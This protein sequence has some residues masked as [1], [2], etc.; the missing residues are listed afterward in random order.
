MYMCVYFMYLCIVCVYMCTEVGNTQ[1]KDQSKS[2][3]LDTV[4][5]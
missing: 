5:P 2:I 1:L 4:E 3:W